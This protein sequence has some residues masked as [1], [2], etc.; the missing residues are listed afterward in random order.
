M[1]PNEIENLI[2]AVAALNGYTGGGRV[3]LE[4]TREQ[5]FKLTEG[6]VNHYLDNHM[7]SQELKFHGV[8]LRIKS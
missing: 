5:Y 2:R 7:N 3:V 1:S 4:I 6:V 8:P